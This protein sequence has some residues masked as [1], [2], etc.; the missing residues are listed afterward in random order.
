[1]GNYLLRNEEESVNMS[2]YES[3]MCNVCTFDSVEPTPNHGLIAVIHALDGL[4]ELNSSGFVVQCTSLFIE[5]HPNNLHTGCSGLSEPSLIRG[6]LDIVRGPIRRVSRTLTY[7]QLTINPH[8]YSETMHTVIISHTTK[9]KYDSNIPVVVCPVVLPIAQ[10]SIGF[11]PSN[12][13]T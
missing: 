3:N 13:I 2:D 7:I 4:K 5:W 10:A 8:R 11:N 9:N 1:M 12:L 6:L